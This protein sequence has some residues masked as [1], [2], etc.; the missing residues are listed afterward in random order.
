M[1]RQ[2]E[3]NHTR[4]RKRKRK[5]GSWISTFI[6]VLLILV[7]V[8][9]LLMVPYKDYLISKKTEAI[10]VTKLTRDQIVSNQAKKVTFD[11]D[12]V[13]AVDTLSVIK[14]GV[15][16]QDLPVVGGIAIPAVKMNLPINL[17]T[18]N[19]GMYYGAG[20]LDPNQKMGEGN[21]AL[22]SHHSKHP[23][24]LFA[25][26]M[27]VEYGQKIFLTDLDKVYVYEI[28]NIMTVDP[29]EGSVLDPTEKPIVTLITCSY[30]LVDRIIVQGSL[31]EEVNIKDA[32][33]EM[34]DAFGM[35]QTIAGLD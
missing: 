7:A 5:K 8:G 32:T 2:E 11:F 21:Y 20:T 13:K 31:I 4:S 34:M 3:Y 24:L 35:E 1:R 33:Q 27:R 28:D 10:Q 16:P 29:S 22:A 25:P 9:L 6:G 30:D 26:L 17:G 14:D 23:N 15:N 19:E 18:S 12:E